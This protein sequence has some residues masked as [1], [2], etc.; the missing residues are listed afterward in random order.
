MRNETTYSGIVGNGQRFHTA[1]EA[2]VSQIPHLEAGR[3]RLGESLSRAQDLLKQQ[4]AATAAKQDLSVQLQ[5][6]ISDVQLLAT[7]LRKGVKQHFGARSEKLAEFGLQ[8][9]RGRKAKAAPTPETP[10][11]PSHATPAT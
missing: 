11:A 2:A 7:M 10:P 9:F 1:M 5:A 3:A 4:A 8:P 6:V